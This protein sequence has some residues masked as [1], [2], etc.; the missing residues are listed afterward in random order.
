MMNGGG[1]PTLDFAVFCP[2]PLA[3]G[4]GL[5][6]SSLGRYPF[7]GFGFVLYGC[8]AALF[9]FVLWLFDRLGEPERRRQLLTLTRKP[10]SEPDGAASE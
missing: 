3:V 8:L 4:V 10:E 2:A 9:G 1:V 6:L 5:V 7:E